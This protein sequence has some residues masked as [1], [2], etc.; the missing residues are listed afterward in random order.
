M[1]GRFMHFAARKE[2]RSY[3]G[4]GLVFLCMAVSCIFRH[5]RGLES[6]IRGLKCLICR[7]FA[8]VSGAKT[9]PRPYIFERNAGHVGFLR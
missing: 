2:E 7:T 1:Y 4:E 5:R 9:E 6:Y 3:I 8:I